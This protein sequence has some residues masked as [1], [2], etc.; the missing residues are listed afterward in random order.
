MGKRIYTVCLSDEDR[1]WLQRVIE[2][3]TQSSRAVL[4]AKILL[5]SDMNGQRRF[6]ADGL[7]AEL[8]TTITTVQ[9]TRTE[10][11]KYGL[12]G[13]VCRK[14]REVESGYKY[15]D[16]IISQ[17]YEIS[18]SEPPEGFERWTTRRIAAECVSRGIVDSINSGAVSRLLKK[19]L[20][21]MAG[22]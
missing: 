7:A 4:R 1:A 18:Q 15:T 9:T 20:S 3:D 10:Y 14:K 16:D 11:G 8:G 5:L 22:E 13:A 21:T 2:D 12:E 19:R 17:I 6:T